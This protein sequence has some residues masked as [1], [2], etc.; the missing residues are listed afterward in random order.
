MTM[1]TSFSLL[2]RNVVGLSSALLLLAGVATAS[3][4]GGSWNV[5]A[6]GDWSTAANWAGSTVADGANNTA[7]F[8][9]DITVVRTVNLDTSRTIGNLT[10]NDADTNTV[11]GWIITNSTLTLSGTATP[12]ITVN[13][14][15]NA[16]N[17]S[18]GPNDAKIE[19][20]LAGSQGFIKKGPGTLLL[21]GANTMGAC[22]LDEGIIIISNATALGSQEVRYNGGGVRVVPGVTF[23]NT[24]RVLTTGSI[25]SL[26][27]NYDAFNGPWV[28]SGTMYIH[29]GGRFTPG[30]GSAGAFSNFTGTIEQSDA[31]GLIRINLGGG[32]LYDMSGVTL[33]P[34]AATAQ[35][36]AFRTTVA[37]AT[38]RI[39]ALV[40]GPG[41][42]RTSEQGGGTSLIWEIGCLN[43]STTFSGALAEYASG[44]VGHLTKVGIGTLTLTGNST[45]TGSTT[46]SNGT[47]ALSGSGSV[48]NSASTNAQQIL[49]VSPGIFDVSGLSTEYAL[50]AGRTLTGSGVVTGNVTAASGL[51]SPGLGGVGTLNFSNNLTLGGSGVTNLFEITGPGNSDK[52]VIGGDLNLNG[53]VVVR[54]IPTGATIPSGTYTLYK[55]SGNLNGDTNNLALEYPPQTGTLTLGMN[56]GTKEIYLQVSGVAGAANLTWRGD[57]S[58]NDWDTATANWRDGG[59]AAT[60]KAGDKVTFDNSG[61][62]NVPVNLTSAMNPASLTVNASK[63]Y[64]FSTTGSGRLTGSGEMIKTNSG[65]L[66]ITTDDDT[67]GAL[68]IAG[69][70]VQVGNAGTTGALG[71]SPISIS[72]NASLVFNRSDSPTAANN[73][74]GAGSVVQNGSGS[75]LTLS[76]NNTH[77][78]GTIVSNGTLNVAAVGLGTGPLV[79][80]GGT[81]SAGSVAIPN[82]LNVTSNSTITNGTGEIQFTGN[83]I[84]GSSNA[85]VTLMG[86]QM[87]FAGTNF[88]FN[89][90]LDLQGSFVLRGY[91]ITGTQTF[92]GVIS[93]TGLYQRRW[94]S[95]DATNNGTTV[96]NGANTY[97]GGTLLREG[98]IGFGCDSVGTPGSLV[99]GPVGT[100]GVTQDIATYTS[101]FASGGA[102]TVGNFIQLSTNPASIFNINGSQD[103]NLSGTI[104]LN[105]ATKTIQADNTARSILSG[106]INNGSLV[107]TGNG[108][109][110]VNGNNNAGSTVVSNGTLGGTGTFAGP[111]TVESGGTLAPG[112]SV[113]TLTI[114]SDLTLNGNL[115][116]EVNRSLSPSNDIVNVSGVLTNGGSGTVTVN[117]LGPALA[118][119][120]KFT[121]FN[122]PL[123][124]G[125]ALTVTGASATWSNRLA[126]DGSIVMTAI[127]VSQP[128]TITNVTRLGDGNV[129]FSFSGTGG[130][131]Y[132]IWASTNVAATP[133]TNT[134]TLLTNA[135]FSGGMETFKDL[136]ATNFPRRF[137]N[138]TAP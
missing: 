110:Y 96:F 30:G 14:T 112:S 122:Q 8:A 17:G 111:V 43:T 51:I 63:D 19:S 132:R 103:L 80:A 64:T 16:A 78:G 126:L 4:A 60:F 84:S 6:D 124:N 25:T 83:S 21:F 49:V 62:N 61:S 57:G 134:W 9:N 108:A 66:V 56:P 106:D 94:L 32:S 133:V 118:A 93:G 15:N 7:T 48:A 3:A 31:A 105:G 72:N 35:R 46:V 92:N 109:L 28:G 12:A 98:G 119:G 5:D 47:L 121:L 24:N 18:A 50:P 59:S 131:A 88:T 42:L 70:V 69:G 34:G 40:G 39:G 20:V 127:V 36:I 68:T 53:A 102:R 41:T 65:R 73:I 97:S 90:G 137:Y 128:T 71:T 11:A 81:V 95:S 120:N 117:N 136:Q 29:N 91:N 107:K 115:A 114:N 113:G 52:I 86:I 2:I 116:I 75:T 77:T 123:L 10:F 38:V 58:A 13:N 33:N 23:A 87:R 22:Q 138:I 85:T 67:S 37:P 74:S 101:V 104:D 76:G 135:T 82:P 27:G 130:Q 1:K 44:R 100:M 55:W 99:S 54:T 89:S 79:L 45:Y 129:Q 125:G 26:D